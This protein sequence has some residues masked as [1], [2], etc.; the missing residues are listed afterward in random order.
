MHHEEKIDGSKVRQR[1]ESFKDFFRQATLFWNSMS[2]P[3][4]QHIIEAFQFEVGSCKN[5][6]VKQRV[7]DM[8]NQ[9]D[10]FLA[11]Q[12][13]LGVGAT[14]P[15][16]PVVGVG[17]AQSAALSQENTPK[18]AATRK[19]AVLVGNGFSDDELFQVLDALK[20]AGVHAEIV[21]TNM[22]ILTGANRR[23]LEVG[24]SFLK[25]ASVLYD[26]VYVAGGRLSV[27]SLIKDGCALHFINEAFKHMKPIGA[28]NEGIDL[29][30]RS[31]I[32]GV[33]MADENSKQAVA[34]L[35]VVTLRNTANMAGFSDE[36]LKAISQHRHWARL[37]AKQTVP[38]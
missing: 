6:Q 8:F 17:L 28:T 4:K 2:E 23:Q 34:D 30:L 21:S 37:P 27:D 32:T 18:S 15:S 12:I 3:E 36:F 11:S 10:H 19:V 20:A 1:S 25:A 16:A 31:Q 9:V 22:T 7:V 26:A 38:A 33:N 5:K 29:L 24:K 35:G 13:A 14:P